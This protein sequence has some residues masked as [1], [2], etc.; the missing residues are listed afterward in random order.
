MPTASSPRT[1]SRDVSRFQLRK[2]RKRRQTSRGRTGERMRWPGRSGSGTSTS[3][4]L[5]SI[6]QRTNSTVA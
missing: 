6:S 5:S 4:P 3:K 2:R 1:Y